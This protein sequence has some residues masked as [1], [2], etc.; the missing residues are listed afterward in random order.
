VHLPTTHLPTAQLPTSHLPTNYVPT[1]SLPT[2]HFPTVHF[3]SH[4][5]I[6]TAANETQCHTFA[7]FGKLDTAAPRTSGAEHSSSTVDNLPQL[8]LM[9]KVLLPFVTNMLHGTTLHHGIIAL[10]SLSYADLETFHYD[11]SK[12]GQWLI[13]IAHTCPVSSP[14]TSEHIFGFIRNNYG[15]NSVYLLTHILK[16]DY[17]YITGL[18]THERMVYFCDDLLTERSMARRR[19]R[20]YVASDNSPTVPVITTSRQQCIDIVRPISIA[21]K[22]PS[23]LS[24]LM[25]VPESSLGMLLGS[26]MQEWM[27]TT[28]IQ[29]LGAVS[30]GQKDRHTLQIVWD[31][32]HHHASFLIS[33]LVSMSFE[34]LYYMDDVEDIQ[35]LFDGLLSDKIKTAQQQT[36]LC[37]RITDMGFKLTSGPIS[38]AH[39]GQQGPSSSHVNR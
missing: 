27:T 15:C 35:K 34:E 20:A 12:F 9:Y 7:T 38:E 8:F 37:S 32:Y 28:L 4:I 14:S 17:T 36:S 16:Q 6:N 5:D 1:A 19:H 10:L 33:H 24:A 18:F 21:L 29:E 3:P 26:A 23:L 30:Y 22:A 25:E 13:N 2:A 31:L 39:H 11:K